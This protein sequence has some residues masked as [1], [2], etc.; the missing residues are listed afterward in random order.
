MPRSIVGMS[1]ARAP[2]RWQ[3][4]CQ[5]SL[6]WQPT[7]PQ[8]SA[9]LTKPTFHHTNYNNVIQQMDLLPAE[10]TA[11]TVSV[12]NQ[13]LY[14]LS[15]LI[16]QCLSDKCKWYCLWC[17]CF[18]QLSGWGGYISQSLK[19][20]TDASLRKACRWKLTCARYN[21]TDLL[22]DVVNSLH[23]VKVNCI[24]CIICYH[25]VVVAARWHYA[26]QAILVVK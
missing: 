14:L 24:V 3:T 21:F 2:D 22:F 20:R 9:W 5:S 23:A 15:Q 17:N 11:S 1:E 18:E 16:K 8:Q 25:C 19:D 6:S 10:A 26:L 4:G 13:R 7:Q 12:C